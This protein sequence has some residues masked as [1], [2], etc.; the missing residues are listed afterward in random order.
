M[1]GSLWFEQHKALPAGAS[2][3]GD[4]CRRLSLMVVNRAGIRHL[5][6]GIELISGL[7]DYLESVSFAS[8]L[9]FYDFDLDALLLHERS[10]QS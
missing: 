10:G 4:A 5:V 1:C 8:F 7:V 2:S 3:A 6:T 9:A